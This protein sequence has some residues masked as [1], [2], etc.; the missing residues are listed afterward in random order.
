MRN[1]WLVFNLFIVDQLRDHSFLL[2]SYGSNSKCVPIS[3]GVQFKVPTIGNQNP[4]LGRFTQITIFFCVKIKR[5][6]SATILTF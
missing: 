1:F 4:K 6:S 5:L 3:D 2:Y